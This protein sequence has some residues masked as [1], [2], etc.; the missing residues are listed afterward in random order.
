MISLIDLPIKNIFSLR[1]SFH[2]FMQKR[3]R[4]RWIPQKPSVANSNNGKLERQLSKLWV[5]CGF[6]NKRDLWKT[7][8]L[9]TKFWKLSWFSDRQDPYWLCLKEGTN[10]APMYARQGVL[11][12]GWCGC[13]VIVWFV[14]MLSLALFL[15]NTEARPTTQTQSLRWVSLSLIIQTRR[16]PVG[17]V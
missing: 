4:N 15:A 1:M 17:T 12:L 16:E 6:V 13:K 14:R 10:K 9:Q 5:S 2:R 7:M 8:H 11:G 3:P